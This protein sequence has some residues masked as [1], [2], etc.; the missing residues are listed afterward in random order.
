MLVNKFKQ[1]IK[2]FVTNT[3]HMVNKFK[4]LFKLFITNTSITKFKE[5]E[6]IYYKQILQIVNKLFITEVSN[7]FLLQTHFC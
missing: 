4:H 7:Y 1:N 5:S 2:L 6:I 3:W